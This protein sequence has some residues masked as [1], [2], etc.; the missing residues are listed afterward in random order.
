[1]LEERGS[2]DPNMVRGAVFCPLPKQLCQYW[3]FQRL[4]SESINPLAPMLESLV[5]AAETALDTHIPSAMVSVHH[6]QDLQ[7]ASTHVQTALGEMGVNSWRGPRRVVHHLMPALRLEGPCHDP[8][9]LDNSRSHPQHILAIDHTRQS[10][11][12]VMW[13]EECGDYWRLSTVSSSDYGHDAITACRSSSST[14]DSSSCD[15]PLQAA[16][17]RLVRAATN[18]ARRPSLGAVLVFGEKADDEKLLS[19]L[20]KA[21]EDDFANGASMQL[22]GVQDFSPDLAFVASRAAAMSDLQARDW[23]RKMKEEEEEEQGTYHDEL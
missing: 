9:D 6:L 14:E 7:A 17:R 23:Q 22:T 1:M 15:V 4:S 11:T 18:R 10:M 12:A 21:L 20:G 19:V 8:D 5:H 13:G 16:F 3:P 2:L